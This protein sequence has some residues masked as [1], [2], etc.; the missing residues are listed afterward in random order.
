MVCFSGFG[1]RCACAQE[2]YTSNFIHHSNVL[3]IFIRWSCI[4]YIDCWTLS[5]WFMYLSDLSRSSDCTRTVS[6]CRCTWFKKLVLKKS[7]DVRRFFL[8]VSRSA[9]CAAS[10]G[11]GASFDLCL[12]ICILMISF[13]LVGQIQA[14]PSCK[15]SEK[16]NENKGGGLI[17]TIV[18]KT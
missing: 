17:Y 11:A 16:R 10:V 3:R 13:V 7:M 9:V 4:L 8:R 18:R 5:F 2:Q 14:N 6:K 1:P 12:L 15:H